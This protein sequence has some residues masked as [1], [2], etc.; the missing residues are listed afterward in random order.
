MS[1]LIKNW[2]CVVLSGPVFP[3]NF[4]LPHERLLSKKTQAPTSNV[5]CACVC[6]IHLGKTLTQILNLEKI[7]VQ[8]A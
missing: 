6:V 7:S 4:L 3:S 2:I 5:C 8:K 1:K